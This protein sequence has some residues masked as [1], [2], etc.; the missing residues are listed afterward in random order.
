M[1]TLRW[2]VKSTRNLAAD[3]TRQGH[4]VSADTVGDLLR[5]EG[6]SLQAGAKILEG[7]QHSDRDAQFH[8][9]NERARQHMGA[10]Q[11]VISVDTKKKEL[12]GNYK[13]AGPSGGRPVS[14]CWSRRTTCRAAGSV[15]PPGT[16]WLSAHCAR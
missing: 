5:Q 14:R 2:T 15:S 4:P 3:L 12:V 9:I 10:G 8:Y 11:P 1:S 7:K 13:N 16:R 6:F